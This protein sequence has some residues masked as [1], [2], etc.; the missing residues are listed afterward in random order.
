VS[1][2]GTTREMQPKNTITDGRMMSR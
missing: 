2:L 1:F